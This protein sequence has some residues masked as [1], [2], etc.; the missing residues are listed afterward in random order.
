MHGI[1]TGTKIDHKL[2]K[3]D[4][5]IPENSGGCYWDHHCGHEKIQSDCVSSSSGP[6]KSQTAEKQKR[7]DFLK[8]KR[9]RDSNVRRGEDVVKTRLESD[10]KAKKVVRN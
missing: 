9:W 8:L 6:M 4:I 10:E 1:Q 3:N 2:D 5:G 7:T